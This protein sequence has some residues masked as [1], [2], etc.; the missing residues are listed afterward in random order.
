MLSLSLLLIQYL[1]G[2]SL[3]LHLKS[4][5]LLSYKYHDTRRSPWYMLRNI[6]NRAIPHVLIRYGRHFWYRAASN[7]QQCWPSGELDKRG[8]IGNVLHRGGTHAHKGVGNFFSNTFCS[9]G[10]RLTL[11]DW[12][13]SGTLCVMN[14]EEGGI[15]NVFALDVICI[16]IESF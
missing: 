3:P 6:V 15:E 14:W 2:P 13:I 9:R 7:S 5:P 11:M 10:L 4:L 8:Y 1:L 16:K 12:P